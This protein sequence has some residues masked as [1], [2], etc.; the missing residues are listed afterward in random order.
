MESFKSPEF[1][2]HTERAERRRFKVA[3]EAVLRARLIDINDDEQFQ[4]EICSHLLS[5][6]N[7]ELPPIA[8]AG[9]VSLAV[10]RLT[11]GDRGNP[12]SQLVRM[13]VPYLVDAMIDDTQGRV[14]VKELLG[15]SAP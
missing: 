4:R 3:D 10:D 6:A 9:V 7:E 1:K 8:I 15:W 14:Q 2:A 11:L 13:F 5:V 12:T